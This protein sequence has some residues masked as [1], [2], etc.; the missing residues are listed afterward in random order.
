MKG[1]RGDWCRR[2]RSP[3]PWNKPIPDS[4]RLVAVA[5]K[6]CEQRAVFE[7][8]AQDMERDASRDGSEA[9]PGTEEEGDGDEELDHPE[10][11][12]VS[13]ARVRAVAMHLLADI[14]ASS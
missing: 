4:Y 1:E 7:S 6:L 10:V 2:G 9:C 8:C 5:G 14:P 12:R 3:D 11:P 13:N